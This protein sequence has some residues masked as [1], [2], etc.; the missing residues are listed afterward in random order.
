MTTEEPHPSLENAAAPETPAAPPP[1]QGR[2]TSEET[3]RTPSTDGTTVGRSPRALGIAGAVVGAVLL[4]VA[5]FAIGHWVVGHGHHNNGHRVERTVRPRVQALGSNRQGSNNRPSIGGVLPDLSQLRS[6][7]Q[8]LL[9]NRG[10]TNSNNSDGGPSA[11]NSQL[12]QLQKQV[13]QLEA[14]V[15]QLQSQLNSRTPQPSPTP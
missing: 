15:K 4:L 3:V 1:A 11:S 12:N 6:L 10:T 13:Q 2:V 5:G 8:D 14:Q 7:L 9:R